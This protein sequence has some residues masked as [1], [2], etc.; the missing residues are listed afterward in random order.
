MPNIENKNNGA[1]MQSETISGLVI[2]FYKNTLMNTPKRYTNAWIYCMALAKRFNEKEH[3]ETLEELYQ[4]STIG[5]PMGLI[6]SVCF[7]DLS[8][9]RSNCRTY[10][11]GYRRK[12]V[13]LGDM[14]VALDKSL[15]IMLDIFTDICVKNDIDTN[16]ITPEMYMTQGTG[17]AL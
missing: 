7:R 11:Y 12:P 6:E 14:I 16:L 10:N 8:L 4:K 5:Y 3:L 9:G 1:K 15:S 2:L 17:A 13:K